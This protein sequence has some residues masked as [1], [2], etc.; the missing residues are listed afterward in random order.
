M[1]ET[2]GMF[3]GIFEVVQDDKR[4][5]TALRMISQRLRGITD[6]GED[7]VQLVA[8]LREEFKSVADIDLQDC[9]LKINKNGKVPVGSD[10]SKL[11]WHLVSSP[12][13]SN[14]ATMTICICGRDS[15]EIADEILEHVNKNKEPVNN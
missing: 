15:N 5:S 6:E 4:A 12:C 8:K 2:I 11:N 13:N 10:L 9:W 3:T 1:N 14:L 7:S